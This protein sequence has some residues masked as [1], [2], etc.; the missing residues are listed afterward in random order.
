MRFT[1]IKGTE[2]EWEEF[3][4]LTKIVSCYWKYGHHSFTLWEET[5]QINSKHFIF[6]IR[7]INER[8]LTGRNLHRLNWCTPEFHTVKNSW[9]GPHWAPPTH[10]SLGPLEKLVCHWLDSSAQD[11]CIRYGVNVAFAV[12]DKWNRKLHC[13]LRLSNSYQLQLP[14]TKQNEL[15]LIS[16]LRSSIWPCLNLRPWHQCVDG[17]AFHD[18]DILE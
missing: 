16:P 10:L 1:Q 17:K 8:Y 7:F 9:N 2:W 3:H 4:P 6:L 18:L 5:H 14:A 15:I 13:N 11:K 12:S